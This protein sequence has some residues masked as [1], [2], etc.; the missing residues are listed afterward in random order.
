MSCGEVELAAFCWSKNEMILNPNKNTF[1]HNNTCV[2]N[3]YSVSMRGKSINAPLSSKKIKTEGKKDFNPLI[4][5]CS[6]KQ[7]Y[8]KLNESQFKQTGYN[9]VYSS[10]ILIPKK[11]I[12]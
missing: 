12:V 11:D 1:P 7:I 9:Y 4:Y 3:P 5:R 10:I 6:K 2:L 8:N